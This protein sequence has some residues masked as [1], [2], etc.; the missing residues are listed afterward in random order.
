MRKNTIVQRLNII[1]GQINGLINLI[2]K[3][4][5][6][7]KITIQFYAIN[8]S[9]KKTMEMYFKKNINSCLKSVNFKKKKTIDFLLEGLIKN[10]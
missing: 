8:S 5:D 4:E 1:N 3:K 7:R 6:C 10:K 2:E 9:L